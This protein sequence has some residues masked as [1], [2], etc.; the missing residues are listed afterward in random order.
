[1]NKT[2]K[3][4]VVSEFNKELQESTSIIVLQYKGLTVSDIT[5][6][7]KRARNE[8]IKFKVVKNRLASLSF[9][10]TDFSELKSE[11]K[12]QNA[13]AYASDPVS[14][15]KLVS[16]FSKENEKLVIVGGALGSDILDKNQILELSKMPSLDELRAKLLSI[17]NTP[18]TRLA[19]LLKEPAGQLARVLN[20]YSDK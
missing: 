6:L 8:N 15:A 4:E 18:A 12:G 13:F 19:T 17:I 3:K 14:V 16:D 9:E 1:M 11:L 2:Q 7:R 20:A 5:E 10:N